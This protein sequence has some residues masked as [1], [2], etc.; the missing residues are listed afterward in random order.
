MKKINVTP[1][2]KWAASVYVMG[3]RGGTAEGK[4][5]AAQAILDM[6]ATLDFIIKKYKI[7]ESDLK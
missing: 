3:L 5:N 6:G 1:S 2:W 4:K 7:K